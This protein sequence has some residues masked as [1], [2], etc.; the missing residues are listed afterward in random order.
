MANCVSMTR[1]SG[2]YTDNFGRLVQPEMTCLSCAVELGRLRTRILCLIQTFIWSSVECPLTHCPFTCCKVLVC[3]ALNNAIRYY[4][5]DDQLKT[6]FNSFQ[7]NSFL[8]PSKKKLLSIIP[9]SRYSG[10]I[11]ITKTKFTS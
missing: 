8:I 6:L 1:V 7:N 11:I 4:E 10:K 2:K 9:N 5:T 3:H